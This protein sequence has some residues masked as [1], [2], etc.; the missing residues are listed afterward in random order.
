MQLH[1][2]SA[3]TMIYDSSS[4]SHIKLSI[5]ISILS[6]KMQCIPFFFIDILGDDMYWYLLG[7][8]EDEVCVQCG[9][10]GMGNCICWTY[11]PLYIHPIGDIYD[12]GRWCVA[13]QEHKIYTLC[14]CYIVWN[15]THCLLCG[16]RLGKSR[17]IVGTCD[18]CAILDIN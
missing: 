18:T 3:E 13:C 4:P 10:L 5:D 16:S 8:V 11:F 12:L 7:F 6:T 15:Q 9:H 1:Y 2:F 17:F 14:T